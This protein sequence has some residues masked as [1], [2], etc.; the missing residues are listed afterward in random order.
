[1]TI[2]LTLR[3]F[4]FFIDLETHLLKAEVFVLL[5]RCNELVAEKAALLVVFVVVLNSGGKGEE[6]HG[7]VV[8]TCV[9]DASGHIVRFGAGHDDEC[10]VR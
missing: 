9:F 6:S 3:A 4:A 10:D 8:T 1:M 5:L 7:Q 2:A